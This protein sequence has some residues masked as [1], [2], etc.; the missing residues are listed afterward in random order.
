VAWLAFRGGYADASPP[1]LVELA[2]RARP[3]ARQA[4]AVRMLPGRGATRDLSFDTITFRPD[5]INEALALLFAKATTMVNTWPTRERLTRLLAPVKAAETARGRKAEAAFWRALFGEH[6]DA[7]LVSTDDLDRVTRAD[8]DAWLGRV[9]GLRSAALVVVGDV[10]PAAVLRA[11]E[12]LSKESMRPA[13]VADLDT[14]R[15]PA[16][17]KPGA[18]R[19]TAVVTDRPGTLVD[20]R[21]GCLL[22]TSS[23]A[24][25][26]H[27]T[28]LAGA[29]ESR[30]N[31]AIRVEQGDGYGVTVNVQR[32]RDGAT[33][34]TAWTFIPQA[35][36]PRTLS[37]L[38]SHWRRWGQSGFDASELNVARW[39][40]AGALAAA[41]ANPNALAIGLLDTWSADPGAVGPAA[42]RR[43]VAGASGARVGELF[44]TCRANAVLGLT[45]DENDIHRALD[46]AWPG[47]R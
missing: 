43:D 24:D 39:R 14:P 47:L 2:V 25:R 22:P 31:D 45:G 20:L 13:W 29:M 23:A 33:F 4:P 36:L 10:D 38:R 11:A 30:L 46:Q 27:E 28:L 18:E 17:R 15:A 8:V 34:L 42:L 12:I 37:V 16:V 40:A 5:R 41:F 21:L 26:A 1:L 35:S 32:L 9:H 7:R 6:R 3:D 44:A 19:V